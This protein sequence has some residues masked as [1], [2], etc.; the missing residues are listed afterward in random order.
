MRL[1]KKPAQIFLVCAGF[2]LIFLFQHSRFVFSFTFF[3]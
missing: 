3:A 1:N 2:L